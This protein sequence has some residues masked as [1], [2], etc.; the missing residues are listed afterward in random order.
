MALVAIALAGCSPSVPTPSRPSQGAAPSP[1]VAPSST[2]VTPPPPSSAGSP[3]P[4]LQTPIPTPDPAQSLPTPITARIDLTG[5]T[6]YRQVTS[7]VALGGAIWASQYQHVGAWLVRIDPVAGRIN[8]TTTLPYTIAPADLEAGSDGSLWVATVP[9]ATGGEAPPNGT[10]ARINPASGRVV[11]QV[12][13]PVQG[14][15]AP[16]SGVVWVPAGT[17]LQR[18]DAATLKVTGTFPAAGQP[19]TQCALSVTQIAATSTAVYLDPD[20]GNVTGTVDLGVDGRLLG[21][22][23]VEGTDNCW[24]LVGPSLGADPATTGSTLA[25]IGL[26]NTMVVTAQSPPF[27]G[28]VR[29]AGGTFWLLANRTMTAIDPLT[30]APLGPTWQLPSDVGDPTSWTLLGA[31][32]T[33]WWV[34]PSEALRV[35]IQIPTKAA[36]GEI[37]SRSWAGPFT[38]VAAAFSDLDHGI[39]AGATGTEA[40]AGV[41]A[42]TS[43]GGRTW[44]KRLLASPPLFGVTFHGS[45][46]LATAACQTDATSGCQTS[47]LRS[48]DGGLTWTAASDGLEGVELPS[49]STAWAIYNPTIHTAG[50]ASSPNKGRTWQRYRSP[51]PSGFPVFEPSGISFPT[52]TEGWLVCAGGG[53]MGSSA[54]A[55][56]HTVN[57]GKTWRTLFVQ[58]LGAGGVSSGPANEALLGGDYAGIDFLAVGTGWLTTGDGLFVTH[59]GGLSW[60]L[61]GFDDGAGGLQIHDM[62]L[63]SATT[64]IVL[65]TDLTASEN[66]ISLERTTDAGATWVTLTS[67]TVGN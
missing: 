59:D 65:V 46:V 23:P 15:I 13:L 54:K 36:A 3:S 41:V 47:L 66:L 53:A 60:R 33:L 8:L 38:P 22:D 11:A 2:A 31:G 67:W 39:L 25:E 32:G 51:C 50:V 26:E 45:L 18:L 34:G 27:Q 42:M 4:I 28:D 37:S 55:L 10:V 64:G 30:L 14:Q 29:F 44:T 20:S 35:G 56:F 49:A 19:A 7:A 6:G 12:E 5:P 43:D 16:G 57:A 9:G 63:L 48:T 17:K 21:N 58:S 62:N 24:V 1:S 52:P 61:V 40:G